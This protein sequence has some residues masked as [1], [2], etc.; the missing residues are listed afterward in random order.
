MIEKTAPA[1]VASAAERTYFQGLPFDQM[2]RCF[3]SAAVQWTA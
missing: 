1:A 2:H 3:V